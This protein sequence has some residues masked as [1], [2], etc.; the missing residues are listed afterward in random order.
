MRNHKVL[1][2]IMSLLVSW[3]LVVVK[4]R[5]A[6]TGLNGAMASQRVVVVYVCTL[7]S[8]NVLSDGI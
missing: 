1:S 8:L 6:H 3:H 7:H 2:Y 4:V 5:L